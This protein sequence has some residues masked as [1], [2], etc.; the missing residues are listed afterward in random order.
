[1]GWLS[2]HYRG[3]RAAWDRVSNPDIP[4]AQEVD[5]IFCSLSGQSTALLHSNEGLLPRHGGPFSKITCPA[6]DLFMNQSCKL[7]KVVIHPNIHHPHLGPHMPGQHIDGRSPPQDM[8]DHLGSDCP[9]IGAHSFL[10]HPVI[11]CED[12][13]HLFL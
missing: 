3:N 5:S 9:R 8:V 4:C 13:N 1:M 7:I 2:G 11:S 10:G 12:V 6:Q